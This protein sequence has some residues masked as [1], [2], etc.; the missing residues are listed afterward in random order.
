MKIIDKSKSVTQEQLGKL[1]NISGRQR[2]LSQ[3]IPLLILAYD[4]NRSTELLKQLDNAIE[5]FEKS[6]HQL[7]NGDHEENLPGIFSE[8]LHELF[9]GDEIRANER[10]ENFILKAKNIRRKINNG[11]DAF[12][13]AVNDLLA[14]STTSLLDLL[15]EITA[16][17]QAEA[18][19]LSDKTAHQFK[20]N[21]RQIKGLLDNI[22][23]ISR[24]AKI[25]A[26]NTAVAASRLGEHGAE[27]TVVAR[28][29]EKLT[30]DINSEV[31]QVKRRLEL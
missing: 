15:N 24:Q 12:E 25:V 31:N 4:K 3:R 2:M 8:A 1:I 30:Q 10:I 28:E 27:I 18:K 11:D 29:I 5:L 19:S 9:F 21:M 16:V 17:Y 20:N 22:M 6:H 14:L 26:F 7:I 13:N 23:S